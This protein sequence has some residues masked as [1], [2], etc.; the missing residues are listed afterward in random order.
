MI[1]V[2]TWSI[3]GIK[4]WQAAPCCVGWPRDWLAGDPCA[5]LLQRCIEGRDVLQALFR[6]AVLLKGGFV[7]VCAVRKAEGRG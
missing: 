2:S 3:L 4:S 7:L 1:M 5:C 6:R